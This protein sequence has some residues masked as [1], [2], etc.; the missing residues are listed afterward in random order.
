M[1]DSSEPQAEPSGEYTPEL[2]SFAGRFTS[3]PAAR[4]KVRP[5]PGVALRGPFQ[6]IAAGHE[7]SSSDPPHPLAVLGITS[8]EPARAQPYVKNM[9][10]LYESFNLGRRPLD[11]SARP[12]ASLVFRVVRFP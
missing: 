6:G 5:S 4:R 10:W 12:P 8:P 9:E 2:S 7:L 1:V 3:G 11:T